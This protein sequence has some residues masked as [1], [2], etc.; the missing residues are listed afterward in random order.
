MFEARKFN[1]NAQ[2][3]FIACFNVWQHH[4]E[5]TILNLVIILLKHGYS[6]AVDTILSQHVLRVEDEKPSKKQT[7]TYTSYFNPSAKASIPKKQMEKPSAYKMTIPTSIKIKDFIKKDPDG[8]KMLYRALYGKGWKQLAN[9]FVSDADIRRLENTQNR[10]VDFYAMESV[11]TDHEKEPL[12]KLL[13]GCI[14]VKNATAENCIIEWYIRYAAKNNLL[15][16]NNVNDHVIDVEFSNDENNANDH[17]I[18][19]EFNDEFRPASPKRKSPEPFE[20]HEQSNGEDALLNELVADGYE[21]SQILDV[22]YTLKNEMR[23]QVTL[24]GVL[25][26]LITRPQ[27][28]AKVNEQRVKPDNQADN[29]ENEENACKICFEGPL[30]SAF[31]SCGHVCTCFKCGILQKT[32]PMCRAPATQVIRIYKS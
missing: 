30:D 9:L 27:K 32:C 18:Y 22:F 16:K 7:V 15:D 13:Q 17:V 14:D 23:Q 5:A 21:R 4:D 25:E 10:S 26:I 31:V 28:E 3:P 24:A 8:F 20:E 2:H 1:Y 6:Q 29:P 11:L 19:V 12:N